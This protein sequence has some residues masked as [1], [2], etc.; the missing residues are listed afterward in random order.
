MSLNI[1]LIGLGALFLCGIS[2]NRIEDCT[3]I[4]DKEYQNAAMRDRCKTTC[5]GC[6][7]IKRCTDGD[8]KCW[9]ACFDIGR[10]AAEATAKVTNAAGAVCDKLARNCA[11]QC[12]CRFDNDPMNKTCFQKC[13]K[14]DNTHKCDKET[15]YER[16]EKCWAVCINVGQI[17]ANRVAGTV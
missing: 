13:R 1:F 3:D 7:N 2:A 8:D 6:R 17:A 11:Q 15:V 12:R 9:G 10:A 14:C 16:K 4:C 5:V